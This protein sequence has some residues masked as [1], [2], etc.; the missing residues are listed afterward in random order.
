MA[1]PCFLFLSSLETREIYE[2]RN[3]V[4]RAIDSLV[5][6]FMSRSIVVELSS[7][8]KMFF[9]YTRKYVCVCQFVTRYVM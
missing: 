8:V 3:I 6:K 9:V 1:S 4:L 2:Y 7:E 5:A